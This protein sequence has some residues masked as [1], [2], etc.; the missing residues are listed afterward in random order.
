M[1]ELLTKQEHLQHLDFLLNIL[2]A[3]ISE[4]RANIT[5]LSNK[6][7]YGVGDYMQTYNAI[8]TANRSHENLLAQLRYLIY[9]EQNIDSLVMLAEGE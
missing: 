8:Y 5:Y 1:P 7:L 9:L 6:G 3:K 2:Y 4:S